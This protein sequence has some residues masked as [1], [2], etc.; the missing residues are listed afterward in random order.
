MKTEY[1]ALMNILG[2]A[3]LYL[4]NGHSFFHYSSI[5][6]AITAIGISGMC[7]KAFSSNTGKTKQ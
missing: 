5:I 3:A 6:Y 2:T 7:A 1:F 4:S